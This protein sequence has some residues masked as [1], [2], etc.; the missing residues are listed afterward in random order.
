[1]KLR[2]VSLSR[3]LKQLCMMVVDGCLLMASL[4]LSFAL[5]RP[6]FDLS[7]LASPYLVY[8]VYSAI[9]GVLIFRQ[10][11]LYRSLVLYMGLQSGLVIFKGITLTTA[12]I[13]IPVWVMNSLSLP[14]QAFLVFWMTGLVL[15]GGLRFMAKI[16]MQNMIQNFRPREPVI[17]YGAGSSGMQLVAALTNGSQ[18]LPVAFVDDSE[19][20]AGNTLHGIR[21]YKQ[22][23]IQGLIETYSV[24]QILLAIPSAT[25]AERK[26]ILNCLEHY[27]VHVRTVPDMFDM[28][29]G[30]VRVD[31][32]RDIEI[33]DLL[34][35]DIVPPDPQLLGA[36]VKDANVLVTGAGGSIGS[37]LCR[38]ILKLKPSTLVLYDN[39]EYGL[40]RIESELREV[41]KQLESAKGTRIVALLGS[42]QNRILVENVIRRFSVRTVYH[43]A[44][45]KQVPMVEKNMVEG[46]QNN[47]FGTLVL[48]TAAARFQVE[49]FVFISTDKAVR[50]ANVMG[51]TKR[52]AEQIL[53][54]LAAS[55]S[56]T[57]FSMVRFGNVLGS[58]GSVVPLFR[59]QIAQGGPVTVTHSEV[60]RY[61]MTVQEAA[62]LVIQAGS[63]ATG[64]DVFVLD[65]NEPVRIV[66]LARKMIH[67]MGYMIKDERNPNGDITIEYTGLR[68]GE[69]LYEELL[70]GEQVTGTEHPKI[71][72]AE[73]DFLSWPEIEALLQRLQLA[74]NNL[75]Q[76]MLREVL[77]EAIGGFV[78]KEAGVDPILDGLATA[79]FN[80][81]EGGTG[82]TG[83]EQPDE[84]RV[85]GGKVL[86]LFRS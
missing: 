86:P 9:A 1:M 68:P 48:A 70:I 54:A 46:V 61:F 43:A 52:F 64:G 31:E 79:A 78:S 55:D 6:G 75:D 17:I 4:W 42:V 10:A 73:E 85:E 81:R 5:I 63:M 12:V 69:K 14:P 22:A 84:Q 62:Q 16:L 30:K 40:Y 13:S 34:G 32:I 24:R 25:H 53:Q 80:D 3:S 18:Y 38:Q 21:V 27:P 41:Q 82:Q 49:N 36:C 2:T 65:M 23:A 44:A 66:D 60:T 45:Y 26:Q 59:Q 37:E 58:S 50:P 83:T 72:R 33:E 51:A 57:R 47:I 7:G 67:L 8:F 77:S 15:V 29:S 35:R 76:Q 39:S 74:C 11:G 20:L 56:Q 71:M 28:V 19:A